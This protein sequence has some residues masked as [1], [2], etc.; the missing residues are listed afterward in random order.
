MLSLQQ[1][2]EAII[3][4]YRFTAEEINSDLT[5]DTWLFTCL[6]WTW[7]S[8]SNNI[9]QILTHYSALPIIHIN[10]KRLC[11]KPATNIVF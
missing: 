10:K 3:L 5:R 4:Q 2:Q 9:F 7:P 8:L 6:A 11:F 1:L